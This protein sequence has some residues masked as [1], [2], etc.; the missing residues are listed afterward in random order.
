RAELHAV[1]RAHFS[2]AASCDDPVH[3]DA[4]ELEPLPA[5][6][7]RRLGEQDAQSLEQRH[8][9]RGV[10]VAVVRDGRRTGAHSTARS[11]G[12]RLIGGGPRPRRTTGGVAT[13]RLALHTWTLDTTPLADV[14]RIA[15]DVG[16][17]AIELRR[18]DFARAAQAGRPAPVVL[19]QVKAVGLPV[20][21]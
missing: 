21:C 8:R 15:R 12:P 13:P 2:T 7:P 4:P 1:G 11:R 9:F 19:D 20:A 14:L 6:A 10:Q 17:N 5:A 3:A 16:W 18:L